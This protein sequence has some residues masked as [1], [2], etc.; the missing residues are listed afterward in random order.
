[1]FCSFSFYSD[2]NESDFE[3]DPRIQVDQH[4][5]VT[6]NND[7]NVIDCS[8]TLENVA[9]D[10]IFD[11]LQNVRL[12]NAKNVIIGHLNVNSVGSKILEIKELQ[13]VCGLDVLVLSPN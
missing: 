12:N 9:I 7:N 13:R 1:M 6:T 10:R 2:C 4:D 11:E 5:S 3:N 8:P